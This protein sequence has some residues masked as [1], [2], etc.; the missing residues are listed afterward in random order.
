MAKRTV[1]LKSPTGMMLRKCAL[2]Q[3]LARGWG[4]VH[5]GAFGS[6]AFI[7]STQTGSGCLILILLDCLLSCLR[8]RAV[9]VPK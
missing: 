9:S 3:S 6:N 4:V 8:M 1:E 7:F 5:T 2:T